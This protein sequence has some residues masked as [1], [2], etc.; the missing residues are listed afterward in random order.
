MVVTPTERK[1]RLMTEPPPIACSLEEAELPDRARQMAE[2]GHEL[3]EVEAKGRRAL[4]TFPVEQRE[5][6]EEFVK[7]ESACCPF[8]DFTLSEEPVGATLGVGV[9]EGGEWAVRGLVAGFVAG[10]GGLV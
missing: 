10:W 1:T 5:A 7:G 2:L 9:P 4:L 8:F 3:L 6:V